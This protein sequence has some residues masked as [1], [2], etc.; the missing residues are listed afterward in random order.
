[1]GI[2]LYQNISDSKVLNKDIEGVGRPI[3]EIESVQIF[4]PTNVLQPTF[5]IEA[6]KGVE[7]YNYLYFD[8]FNRYYYCTVT[9][10]NHKAIL[11]CTVDPL[12]SHKAG[13]TKISTMVS[14]NEFTY[15]PHLP[16]ERLP[17]NPRK[18][19]TSREIA[20]PLGNEKSYLLLVKG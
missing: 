18:F 8:M 20:S 11:S 17:L 16:D 1:M 15:N 13:I 3:S 4:Q 14:R 5:E 7:K 19:I 12:M 10:E 2:T 6:F 9:L